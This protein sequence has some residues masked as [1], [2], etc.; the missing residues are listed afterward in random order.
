VRDSP[1]VKKIFGI[2]LLS[3]GM[4]LNDSEI[5]ARNGPRTGNGNMPNISSREYETSFMF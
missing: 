1:F 4:P 3:Y 5:K 2:F